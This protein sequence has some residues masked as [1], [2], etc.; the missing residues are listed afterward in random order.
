MPDPGTG[1]GV[2]PGLGPAVPPQPVAAESMDAPCFSQP[3]APRTRTNEAAES[4][5]TRMIDM[6]SDVMH[7]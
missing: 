6:F 1:A 4:T 5:A 7:I 3:H 2:V